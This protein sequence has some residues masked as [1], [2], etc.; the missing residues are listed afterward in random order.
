MGDS[1]ETI[2]QPIESQQNVSI[3]DQK[4]FNNYLRKC[5][6]LFFDDEE[7]ESCKLEEALDENRANQECIKKFLSDPQVQTLYIQKSSNK[8]KC[9]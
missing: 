1:L 4:A 8:G 5:V 9:D 3:V 7:F 2:D 6:N